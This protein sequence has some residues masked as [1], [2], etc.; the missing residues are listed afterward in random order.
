MKEEED[1]INIIKQ[2]AFQEVHQQQEENIFEGDYETYVEKDFY[3]HPDYDPDATLPTEAY[4]SEIEPRRK[5]FNKVVI[6]RAK[7]EFEAP[8]NFFQDKNANEEGSVGN[9][10][11]KGVKTSNEYPQQERPYVEIGLQTSNKFVSKSFQVSKKEYVNSYSQVEPGLSDI[12]DNFSSRKDYYFSDTNRV[13]SIENFLSK[14]RPRMEESLQSNETINIFMND[15]DLDKNTHVQTDEK[16]KNQQEIRTFRDNSAGNKSKKEKC[17]GSIRHIN[18]TDAYVAHTLHRNFTFDERIKIEG[19]PYQSQILFWNIRDVEQ[20]SPIFIVDTPGE[21]TAFEFD[22]LNCNI[23][24]IAL[25][26]GQAMFIKFKDIISILNRGSHNDYS[27]KK[28]SKKDLYTFVLTAPGDS[29]KGKITCIRW[30]PPGYT[31]NKKNQINYM[32]EVKESALVATL[33]DDGVVIV[34][35][36][37][38]IE[39]GTGKEMENDVN[40]YIKYIK[41]EIN[42]VDSIG[43]ING[44]GLEI[45]LRNNQQLLYIS[46]DEGQVYQVD[47]STKNTSDNPTANVKMFYYSRYYRPILAF[48]ISPFFK[49]IFLTV[50]DFHFCLWSQKRTRPI[51]ISANLKKSSYTCGQ[52]SSSRPGVLYL[53]RSNGIID[54]WDFLDESH[55][56]SV[57]D[58]FIKELITSIE[59]FK[60]YPPIE[61]NENNQKRAYIEYMTI[62]DA[63]GQMTVI[64]VPKL[65]SEQGFDEVSIMKKYFD[66]EIQRQEYM[67]TR[68]KELDEG[69]MKVDPKEKAKEDLTDGEKETELK[70][71]EETFPIERKKIML[72]LGFEV[73]KTQEEIEKEKKEAPESKHK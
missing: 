14:V 45:D 46:T 66:N 21:I 27:I 10:E 41:V 3:G 18:D 30:F 72:E 59:V 63:S 51:F 34:W 48:Q 44:T 29:H 56:P 38:D 19:I 28:E 1:I 71:A 54:I 39:L 2:Q 61:D 7:R 4:R 67:E 25:S 50:H 33:G 64:E 52:F 24:A 26:S 73:P 13:I 65:F 40:R 20:N 35:N 16:K 37:R 68:Y 43:R 55:K 12:S 9:N 22:Y 42:K 70:Y 69:T 32:E 31:L 58:S 8:I 60:Y 5:Y 47:I 17:V 11:V 53:C 57:K 49:D 62:G 23:V 6:T 36:I 15:F